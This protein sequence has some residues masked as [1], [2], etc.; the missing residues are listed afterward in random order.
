MGQSSFSLYVIH[1]P[2]AHIYEILG[3]YFFNGWIIFSFTLVFSAFVYKYIEE[4]FRKVL[5]KKF[6]KPV[7]KIS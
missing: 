7:L 5:Q 6:H 4:P 1:I 2:L 3:L